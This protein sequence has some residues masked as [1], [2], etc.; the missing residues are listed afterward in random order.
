MY[1]SCHLEESDEG[2]MYNILLEKA[3]QINEVK[4]LLCESEGQII[5]ECVPN[6]QHWSCGLTKEAAVKTDPE[7]WPGKN[8]LGRMWITVRINIEAEKNKQRNKESVKRKD[9]YSQ[10]E[11]VG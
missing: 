3:S 5:A 7:K 4:E 11:K 8:V 1:T 2:V 10:W 6:Q 9:R